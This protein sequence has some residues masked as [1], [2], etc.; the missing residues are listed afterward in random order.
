LLGHKLFLKFLSLLHLH[1]L[2]DLALFDDKE[3]LVV[4]GMLAIV[5]DNGLLFALLI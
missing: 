2:A 5:W 3:V 1:E 4:L